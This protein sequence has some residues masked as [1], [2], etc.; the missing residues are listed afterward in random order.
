[1]VKIKRVF[2]QIEEKIER[3]ALQRTPGEFLLSEMQYARQMDVSRLTVRKAVDELVRVG[4]VQRIPGKGLM[5]TDKKEPAPQERLLFSLPFITCDAEFFQTMMGCI[6]MANDLHYDYKILAFTDV[7]KRLEMMEHE[8][9][10]LYRGAVVTCYES[11]EDLKVL[12][13]LE[14]A[15]VPYIIC[16]GRD[17]S[18]P[19]V[20]TD[21]Y[22]GG[23]LM[24]EY[25]VQHGHRDILFLT[26]DRPV[27][28]VRKRTEGFRQ[29]LRD[30]L[31]PIREKY[32]LT[33]ADPG[34][35]LLPQ[36]ADQRILPNEARRFLGGEC[37][38]T[39]LCG[40]STLPILSMLFQMHKLGFL[41]P[42]D[43]S[44]VAYGSSPYFPAQDL[45]L[46]AV[47]SPNHEVGARAVEL[48]H[49]YL[50]GASKS[51][52]SDMLPIS[53]SRQKSVRTLRR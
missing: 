39:A 27:P 9:L 45:P 18:K 16:G 28:S 17:D 29:A 38:F 24:G 36:N 2:E 14:S 52:E 21:D 34:I 32:F 35:P 41:V 6:D 40:Y 4:L 33:V 26:S 20:S 25:L 46:T 53:F 44:V 51:V 11:P 30:N 7:A 50:T 23:Y 10:S 47:L 49:R 15:G 1:M 12:Q 8:D 43:V 37:P 42:E 19:S 31:M 48:L 22:N 5:V 3:D 13:L